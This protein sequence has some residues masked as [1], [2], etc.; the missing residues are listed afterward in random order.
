MS[1]ELFNEFVLTP[2]LSAYIEPPT[3]PDQD[4]E[5]QAAK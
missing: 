3:P 2:S 1:Q 5:L 4:A